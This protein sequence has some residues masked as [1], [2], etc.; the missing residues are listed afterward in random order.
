MRESKAW[1][2][3]DWEVS[4]EKSAVKVVVRYTRDAC[5][6]APALPLLPP[7]NMHYASAYSITAALTTRSFTRFMKKG[8]DGIKRPRILLADDHDI[9]LEGIR[10]LLEPEADVVGAVR[11]GWELVSIATRLKP[12]IILLD[13]SMPGLNGIEAARQLHEILPEA[14]LIFLTMYSD[15]DYIADALRR[16]A[17][18]YVLK[19]SATSEI[20][21]A[22]RAVSKGQKY[23]TPRLKMADNLSRMRESKETLTARQREVLQLIAEG[24]SPKEISSQLGISVRTVEFHKYSIIRKLGLSSIAELTKYAVRHRISEA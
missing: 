20:M 24:K 21:A 10:T 17:S 7:S 2:L 22:I 15:A 14:K 13:I 23:V 1:I 16:G 12:D 4:A 3:K 18:G 19:S 11:N 9:V 8:G 5:E 6:T